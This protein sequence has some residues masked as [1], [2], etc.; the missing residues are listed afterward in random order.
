V[1]RRRCL[2][3]RIGAEKL[4]D[5][6][7]SADTGHV[8]LLAAILVLTAP[9]P[10]LGG[11]LGA[12]LELRLRA[13]WLLWIALAVQIAMFAPGGPAWPVLHVVSYALAAGFV[14]CN[15]RLPF[16][17]LLASGGALANGGVMPASAHAAAAAGLTGT[18]PANSAVLEAPRIGFLGDVFA[19][20]AGLPLHN[21]FSVGD[22]ILVVG[23]ALAIHRVAGSRLTAGRSARAGATPDPQR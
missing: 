1:L 23:A 2:V 7:R 8:L 17:W 12:L 15:R 9:V 13:P 3:D 4:E 16:V 21:V 20:P 11:R 6:L 19:L 5:S 10:L 14:W 18:E 22:V